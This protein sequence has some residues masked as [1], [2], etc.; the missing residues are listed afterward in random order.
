MSQVK[1]FGKDVQSWIMEVTSLLERNHSKDQD[2]FATL[3]R[4]SQLSQQLETEEATDEDMKMVEME[5]AHV[6]Q[7]ISGFIND[8]EERAKAEQSVPIGKFI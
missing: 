1:Q 5:L 2:V 6:Y 3:E 7:E 4:L 8:N